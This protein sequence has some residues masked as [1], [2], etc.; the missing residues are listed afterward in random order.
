MSVLPS[1]FAEMGAAIAGI[2]SA[3]YWFKSAK[4]SYVP[5]AQKKIENR[6]VGRIDFNPIEE[7]P[8]VYVD[9]DPTATVEPID[10]FV[11][12]SASLNFRA[13]GWSAATAMLTAGSAALS[14]TGL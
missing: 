3:F 8:G 9:G 7:Q 12:Q 1:V 10:A 14:A 5:T 6:V 13:A 4:L 2:V 11:K